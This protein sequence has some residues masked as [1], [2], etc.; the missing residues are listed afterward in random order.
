[1][2]TISP[3]LIGRHG[4]RSIVIVIVLALGINMFSEPAR[5][6]DLAHRPESRVEIRRF[7]HHVLEAA[8]LL[9]SLVKLIGLL[10]RAQH[11][12]YSHRNMLTLFATRLTSDTR[13]QG[14]PNYRRSRKP[15]GTLLYEWPP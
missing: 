3:T 10:E 1:R 13:C 9:H 2:R 8:G 7:E 4:C 12:R 14:A 6:V 15:S 5:L 11:G